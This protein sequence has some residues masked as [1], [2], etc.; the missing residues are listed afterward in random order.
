MFKR[1]GADVRKY[2]QRDFE[3]FEAFLNGSTVKEL[4]R[5]NEM[6]IDCVRRIISR[7]S[8]IVRRLLIV[9]GLLAPNNQSNIYLFEIGTKAIYSHREAWKANVVVYKEHTQKKTITRDSLLVD[10]KLS[11]RAYNALVY[12]FKTV[13]NLVDVL[14]QHHHERAPFKRPNFGIVS[15]K[16]VQDK[17]EEHGFTV[18]LVK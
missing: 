14:H 8:G 7:T 13:G 16:E 12:E 11:A 3:M 10:L 1:K 2:E 17:L 5:D 18:F 15:K 6:G 9:R 4:A